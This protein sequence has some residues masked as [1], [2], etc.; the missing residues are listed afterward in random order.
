MRAMVLEEGAYSLRDVPIPAPRA[1]EVCIK[2]AY[3]G[4]N[5]ADLFQKQGKYPLPEKHPA[6]PGLEVSGVVTQC[7]SEVK[8]IT[9]GQ[10]VCALLSE[11]AFAEYAVVAEGQVLPLPPHCGLREAAAL[12]EAAM[13]AWISLKWQARLV[14]GET[15]LIH[16]GASGVG[17]LAIQMAI[18]LGARVFATAGSEEKCNA[19]RRL[20]A[21]AIPYRQ[22]DF[23]TVITEATG[24]R[25]VDVVLD[26]VGGDY[27]QRNFS[28]LA[29]GGRLCFISFLKGAKVEVNFGPVLLKH[30]TVTG[31]TLRAR[32]AHEK[33]RLAAEIRDA[34]WPVI[35]VESGI[36]PLIDN[37]FVLEEAEK[38][39]SHME[40]SLNVGKILLKI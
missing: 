29:H 32:P 1:D 39:L 40:Q 34:L 28:A 4:V 16:G 20:G 2:V 35:G 13:T 31:S 36:N 6:I 14:A 33:T 18:H 25:G 27:V 23:V 24:G 15:V 7:G 12:P 11:G 17:S 21:T 19:C 8:H 10:E 38:A 3:A 5:R 30:L 26:M 22:Q 37:V 9:V